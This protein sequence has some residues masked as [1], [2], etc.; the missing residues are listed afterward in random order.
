MR[1]LYIDIETTGLDIATDK[2]TVIAAVV[3]DTNKPNMDQTVNLNVCVARKQGSSKEED[4]KKDLY[5]LLVA[6]DIII[7]YHIHMQTATLVAALALQRR[8]AYQ[9][10]A[11]RK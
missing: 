5:E 1:S 8:V 4:M 3:V 9:S 2:I 6:C 11:H 7:A 10:H